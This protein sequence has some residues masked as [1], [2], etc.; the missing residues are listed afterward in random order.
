M[1]RNIYQKF[2]GLFIL[3][4]LLGLSSN[5]PLKAQC[6]SNETQIIVSITTDDYP[7]ETTWELKNW[8]TD[9]VYASG[10][11]YTAAN[12]DYT[13]NVCI[14]DAATIGFTINDVY[15]DGICCG[16]GN[17]SYSVS[18]NGTTYASGGNFDAVETTLFIIEQKAID[19][20]IVNLST[21][22]MLLANTE[23][24]IGGRITNLGSSFI[25]SFILNWQEGDGIVHTQIFNFPFPSGSTVNFSH[26]TTWTPTAG[27]YNIKVWASNINGGNDNNPGNDILEEEFNVF[28]QIPE[29][30]MLS[31]HFTN[32]SCPP[33]AAQN[34]GFDAL[35]NVNIA[36]VAPIKYHTAWPGFDPM[37]QDNSADA[38]A[39]T[40]YYSIGGVPRV[41]LDGGQFTG[42]P[43]SVTQT[44]VNTI[45]NISSPVIIVVDETK[46]GNTINVE[47]SIEALLP[48]NSN[49]LRVHVVAVEKEINYSSAPGSNGEKDFPY[50]MRKMLPSSNG[51]TIPPMAANTTETVN[52]S[53]TLPN[54][55]DVNEMRTIVFVQDQSTGYVYQSFLAPQ[56]MGQNVEEQSPVIEAPAPIC[57]LSIEIAQ[58]NATCGEDTGTAQVTIAGGATPFTY[59]WTN[60]A[61]EAEISNLEAGTYN[62]LVTDAN[63]CTI[64]ES[65]TISNTEPPVIQ[66]N[67][68]Q[69]TCGESNG[70]ISVSTSLGVSPF[71]YQWNVGGIGDVS[72]AENLEAGTYLVIVTDAV[73]CSDFQSVVLTDIAGPS[74]SLEGNVPACNEEGQLMANVS[75]GT[76]PYSFEWNTG[77]TTQEISIAEAG[78]YQV[79]V[80]D[81][82][83]CTNEE[84]INIES[85]I[86]LPTISVSAEKVCEGELATAMASVSGGTPPYDVQW[87]NGQSGENAVDL[88]TGVMYEIEVVDAAGCST[89]SAFSVEAYSAIETIVFE[90]ID[91][92]CNESN[93]S[94]SAMVMGGMSP[95]TYDWNTGD[96]ENE[97][98][99]LQAGNYSVLVTDANGCT[100][101][102]E[103]SIQSSEAPIVVL[104]T[105]EPGCNGAG[106]IMASVSGG[107]PPYDLQWDTG[108]TE[109]NIAIT[110]GG[111]YSLQVTDDRGCIT[112]QSVQVEANIDVPS[113]EVSVEEPCGEGVGSATVGIEG[114]T[115]PYEI[116][117]ANGETGET[118]NDLL[119]GVF[120][121]VEVTD[122]N[123]CSVNQTFIV[124]ALE[125][126][127][128][129]EAVTN[130]ENCGMGDGRISLQVIG[131][132]APFTFDWNTGE[133]TSDLEGLSA[134]TY[135]VLV[136]DGNGCTEL[137]TIVVEG[138]EGI[139]RID[140]T[141]NA[142]NCGEENGSISL[143]VMG[144]TPPFD[145]AWNTGQIDHNLEGLGAGIYEVLVTDA[146][147]CMATQSVEIEN[148]E[149]PDASFV[150]PFEL[151][152]EDGDLFMVALYTGGGTFLI[153]GEPI[154]G[155]L[156]TPEELGEVTV[157][158][159]V[160]ENGCT[161]TEEQI[162][163]IIDV[164]DAFWTTA[165]GRLEVC[166]SDLPL[167]ILA[168]NDTGHWFAGADSEV[169]VD[170]DNMGNKV[171]TFD[172]AVDMNTD[173]V[174][175]EVRHEGG[176]ENC[177]GAYTEEIVVYN[178]PQAPELILSETEFCGVENAPELTINGFP[179][180]CDCPVTFNIYDEMGNVLKEGNTFNNDAFQTA[181][182]ITE[183]GVYGFEISSV[184]GVCESERVAVVLEVFEGV[185]ANLVATPS[186]DNESGEVVATVLNGTAP[187]EF[188]WSNGVNTGIV[189]DLMPTD[190]TVLITDANGCTYENLVNVPELFVPELD[191]GEDIIVEEG[192][193]VVLQAPV[194]EGVVYVWSTGETPPSITV[195]QSGT[196][197]LTMITTDGC[198]VSDEIEVTF[199]TDIATIG[200][201]MA[202]NLLP[203]PTKNQFS[204]QLNLEESAELRMEIFDVAGRLQLLQDLQ[205]K[206]AENVIEVDTQSF[207]IGVY[208][209]VLK[210][211]KGV[212]MK[213]LVKQ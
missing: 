163:T 193:M 54:F 17:G 82:N 108:D 151:C 104:E 180:F 74:V 15:G 57:A 46:T 138:F 133:S 199:A 96:A 175:F 64:E 10:G 153:N 11:P 118:A 130:A 162:V 123:G 14:P 9:E 171:I 91:A 27:T 190:Y 124:D 16:F 186:C 187:Y 110:E 47:A 173:F 167:T 59:Q 6:I 170:I 13:Q 33:C 158:Y 179:E 136:T 201:L 102:N 152:I 65:L 85:N 154:E 94:I 68:S 29:R 182:F 63:D 115:P 176:G 51:T 172:A 148:L 144:G 210:D 12:N 121:N 3:F 203:N 161:S 142:A 107:T 40:S 70:S 37:Y 21:S 150:V 119:T 188:D 50:V 197:S 5:E 69:P 184:N 4:F 106:E 105:V 189:T 97:L 81:I 135:E 60:G 88:E 198:E 174:T 132:N 24:T 168:N 155:N 38:S 213:R 111:N 116:A 48:I 31:E 128:G 166:A 95:Y 137:Q 2:T 58:E 75:G 87:S 83:G 1:I 36:R 185:S 76:E 212:V 207:P 169:L 90:T 71:S 56:I 44:I 196:Y 72:N 209:V 181:G 30:T 79:V 101:V 34:P 73:G 99:E 84:T 183:S 204:L 114:G 62:V 208:L 194:L 165:S 42:A 191:L 146:N 7:Q 206:A 200:G 103:V 164:F 39:R 211:E 45:T 109:F 127:T 131:G 80:T 177:N 202:W 23:H 66:T 143:E 149:A 26:N 122:A 41:V 192:E 53:Y 89:M 145:Y 120:Y 8:V 195:T 22:T 159:T 140:A 78:E 178:V 61:N 20:A 18:A 32:A 160:T 205:L 126:I 98:S 43:A 35:M 52:V 129:I 134:G 112:I 117:W 86:D 141:A 19:L 125:G 25:N 100:A 93:G 55:V 92:S 28:M 157:A 113:L 49:D 156:W 147:G 139:E 77:G 67:T